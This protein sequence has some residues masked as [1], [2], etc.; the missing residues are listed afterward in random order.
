V[1]PLAADIAATAAWGAGAVLTLV[2]AAELE[3]LGL[4]ALPAAVRAA[5]MDW[6]HV[7]VPD[8][9]PPGPAALTAWRTAGPAL[10]A[11]LAA[12]GR[13]LVH[14]RAGLGRSGTLAAMILIEAGSPPAAALA[15]VRA[16]R[17]GA[18]ETAAQEAF[19]LG[20]RSAPA[21]PEAS[22]MGGRGR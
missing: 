9:A 18:V 10:A 16:A 4:A 19:V 14:C 5:G 1:T 6:L 13:V 15:A 7:P 20:W 21:G 17:P 22:D 2:E 12:G 3:A 8:F 11:R